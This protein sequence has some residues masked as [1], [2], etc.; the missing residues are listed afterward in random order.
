MAPSPKGR[1]SVEPSSWVVLDD[2]SVVPEP[3]LTV[4]EE[5]PASTGLE[6][7][8]SVVWVGGVTLVEPEHARDQGNNDKLDNRERERRRIMSQSVPRALPTGGAPS[9]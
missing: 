5:A 7:E 4:P 8:L 9:K 3:E 1:G 6:E 2:G